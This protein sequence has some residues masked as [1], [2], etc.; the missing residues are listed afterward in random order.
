MSTTFELSPAHR[1]A[2]LT[3]LHVVPPKAQVLM[4][5]LMLDGL[6]L[7]EVLAF[8]AGDISGVLPC[9]DVTVTR[10]DAERQLPLHPTTSGFVAAHLGS[11]S[12]G[13]LL[14]GRS[15][16]AARMTRFGADYL[17]KQAGRAAGLLVPLTTNMLRRSYVTDAHAA[18]VDLEQIRRQLGHDDV[19][20]TRRYLS[21]RQ[22]P[23]RR[24]PRQRGAQGR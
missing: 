7:D 19:R 22:E 6:K 24:R 14:G 1:S 10:D 9:L 8:D 13:P 21:A 12:D 16:D 11:R 3:S 20:T 5:M 17:V 18:G 2:L 23:R 15:D 4:A